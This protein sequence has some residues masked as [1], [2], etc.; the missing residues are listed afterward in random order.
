MGVRLT[1]WLGTPSHHRSDGRQEPLTQID[2]EEWES[3]DSVDMHTV[4]NAKPGPFSPR[5]GDS[6]DAASAATDVRNRAAV[7]SHTMSSESSLSRQ[8]T[9]EK[10]A[11]SFW[12]PMAGGTGKGKPAVGPPAHRT[13]PNRLLG[14]QRGAKSA[15]RAKQDYTVG[16]HAHPHPHPHAHP[17]PHP[18][19]RNSAGTK[20]HKTVSIPYMTQHSAAPSC[21]SALDT[22]S[23]T[24][25]IADPMVAVSCAHCEVSCCVVPFLLRGR[26]ADS[27]VVFAGAGFFANHPSPV[28]DPSMVSTD[29][30]SSVP[31][32]QNR[33][34]R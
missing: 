21:C 22:M 2:S 8:S 32:R 23:H 19:G 33:A 12:V 18:P 3:L 17:H 31:R 5:T 10:C 26:P 1:C 7:M 14:Y 6:L 11:V 16:G 24:G 30:A 29:S 28:H 20:V 34:G 9:P 25:A 13:V 15:P 4:P 27:W